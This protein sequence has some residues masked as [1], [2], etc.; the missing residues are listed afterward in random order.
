[1]LIKWTNKFSD[2]TG[3]VQSISKKEKHFNN[4]FDKKSAKVYKDKSAAQRI[5]TLLTS[6]G[7]AEANDFAII[8]A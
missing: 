6:Y 3:F 7:E 8:S 4:T 1:M 5:I 2:E